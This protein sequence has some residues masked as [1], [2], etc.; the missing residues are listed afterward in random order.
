MIP[1]RAALAACTHDELVEPLV[2]VAT[3]KGA[4]GKGKERRHRRLGHPS[5]KTVVTLGESGANG[6]VIMDLPEKISRSWHRMRK[7]L[8][9]MRALHVWQ[10]KRYTSRIRKGAVAQKNTSVE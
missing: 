5:F 1:A 2:M 7:Y 3:A 4:N 9:L 6:M 10:R 8:V